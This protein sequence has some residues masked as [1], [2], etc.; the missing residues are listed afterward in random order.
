MRMAVWRLGLAQ[1][2]SGPSAAGRG[3]TKG[4]AA[5]AKRE[6]KRGKLNWILESPSSRVLNT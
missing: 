4:H 6:R 5:R 2:R 3:K 1:R